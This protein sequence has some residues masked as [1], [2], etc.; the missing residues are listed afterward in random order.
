MSGPE[1]HQDKIPQ[2]SVLG[3][4]NGEKVPDQQCVDVYRKYKADGVNLIW[5]YNRLIRISAVSEG[6][7]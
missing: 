6:Y 4:R 3:T 1:M 7:L 5:G 2:G